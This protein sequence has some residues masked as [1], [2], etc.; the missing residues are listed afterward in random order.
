MGLAIKG[1]HE[2]P[3]DEITLHPACIHVNTLLVINVLQFVTCYH[4]GKL[5]KEYM[6]SSLCSITTI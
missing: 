6:E 3:R 1:H 2:D 4:C 5:G